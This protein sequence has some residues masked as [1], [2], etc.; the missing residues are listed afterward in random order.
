MQGLVNSLSATLH[1][2]AITNSTRTVKIHF[3]ITLMGQFFPG[4]YLL[5]CINLGTSILFSTATKLF[6]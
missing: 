6:D 4:L 1:S 5:A 3:K 2:L